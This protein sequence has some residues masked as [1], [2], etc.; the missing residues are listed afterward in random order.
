MPD[1]SVCIATYRRP[2]RLMALLKD[3]LQ[4]TVQPNEVVIVDNDAA[5][6]A[7]AVVESFQRECVPGF[8][9]QYAIQPKKNISLTRNKTIELARGEW[10]AFIDDDERP[11]TVWLEQLLAAQ[12]KYS[13]TGILAPVV[14]QVPADAP[15]WIKK[16]G[17]YTLPRLSTGSIVPANMFRIG[18]ALI[19][20]A[21]LRRLEGPFDP[22][23]GLTGGEDGDMLSR[24]AQNGARIHWSDE[25]I[26]DEPVEPS[27]LNLKW[28]FMRSLRGGQDF[29][30]HTQA[31]RYGQYNMSKG[32]VFAGRSVFQ[33]GV[34]AVLGVISL[35]LG[36]HRGA[37]WLFKAAANMGKLSAFWGS[38]YREYA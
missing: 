38:H 26:V 14:A 12:T 16:G 25:A 11:Y 20:A 6:S 31:G 35:P 4:Q 1:I 27:R 5:G 24:L 2:E 29:A 19:E 9:L 30:Y 15:E 28:L 21:A 13:A 23:F 10:L 36:K 33:L 34:A 22:E 7:R 17:F 37:Y 32:L 8:T 3:L 18:N